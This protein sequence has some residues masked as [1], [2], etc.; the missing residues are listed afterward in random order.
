MART[1]RTRYV[2]LGAL[3]FGPRT[4]YEIKKDI[5]SSVGHFWSESPGQLYPIL[6]SL[7][8]EGLATVEDEPHGERP[9]KVYRVTD[10]GRVVFLE[11]L[12]EPPEPRQLR[13]EL[14]L[15]LFFARVGGP[16]V[17]VSH[18]ESALKEAAAAE[19]VLLHVQHAVENEEDTPDR[20]YALITLDFG[21][22]TYRSTQD[23]CRRSIARIR[24]A[25]PAD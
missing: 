23:W 4:G 15:K 3:T 5:E 12:K 1:N 9:R 20:V 19:Q 18:L 11:W 21:L 16:N 14:L 8:D 10:P 6:K 17:A 2:V 22:T 24:D 25:Q 13:N 7:V